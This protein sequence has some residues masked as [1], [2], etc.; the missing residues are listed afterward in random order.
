[1]TT[2][3]K[4]R[5]K[6]AFTLLEL[7]VCLAIISIVG[8]LVGTKG[9]QLLEH[10]QFRST[11]Q[12]FLL[13]LGRFQVLSMTCGSDIVCRITQDVSGCKVHWELETSLPVERE[14]L[15]YGLKGV[16]ALQFQGKPTKEV[17]FILFSSGRISPTHL[18][19]FIPKKEDKRLNIDLV[20]PFYLKEGLIKKFKTLSAPVY[21]SRKKDFIDK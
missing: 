1:M 11:V 4:K 10:H 15:S 14:A 2:L 19:T 18:I 7:L 9:H 17:E 8:V 13:D 6:R 16:E 3:I 20:Y 21:P 12:N 5:V